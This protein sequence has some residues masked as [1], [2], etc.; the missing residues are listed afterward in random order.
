MKNKII[1]GLILI[2][3]LFSSVF[4]V[5]GFSDDNVKMVLKKALFEYFDKPQKTSLD[6]SETKDLLVFYLESEHGVEDVNLDK[7]GDNSN[8]AIQAIISKALIGFGEKDEDPSETCD[9][10]YKCQTDFHKAYQNADCSW[11]NAV[12][13][14]YGC[15]NGACKMIPSTCGDDAIDAG[16]EC[17]GIELG[18]ATCLNVSPHRFIGGSLS[19]GNCKF[20]I[21]LCDI[22]EST[23]WQ[24]YP[25]GTR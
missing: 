5:S 23:N 21:S 6:L 10:G 3:V 15:E 20:N 18:G 7:I 13:C 2:V 11:S 19:C 16:E 12:F 24:D 9:A 8:Q 22:N 14:E 25:G 4:S 1:F 17:D